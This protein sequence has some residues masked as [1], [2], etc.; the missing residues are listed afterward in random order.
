MKP[1]CILFVIAALSSC[2]L[3]VNLSFDYVDPDSGLSLGGG[4]S[5]KGGLNLN[6]S[7]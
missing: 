6:V 3:P 2:K 5:S 4:Y 1:I 7:K